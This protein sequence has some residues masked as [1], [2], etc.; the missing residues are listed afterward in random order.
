MKRLVV[1]LLTLAT[2]CGLC[3][4]D[5]PSDKKEKVFKEI[6]EYKIKFLAQEMELKGDQM[7]KF[8]ETYSRL[9]EERKKNF[10]EMRR[11]EK[12]LDENSSDKDYR[13]INEKLANDRLRDAELEKEYDAKFSKFLTPKQIYKM[14]AAE[15]KFRR[16]M[17]EMGRKHRHKGDR[18]NGKSN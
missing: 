3:F 9:S 14:K 2:V 6:Q 4:A 18:K 1:L 12:Q 13:E 10:M 16:K 11:L 17:H 5:S 7:K 15:D 8:A